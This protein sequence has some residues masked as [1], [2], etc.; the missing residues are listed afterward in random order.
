MALMGMYHVLGVTVLRSILL[1]LAAV[2]AWWAQGPLLSML[3]VV[4]IGL[5]VLMAIIEIPHP[6]VVG[7]RLVGLLS[8]GVCVRVLGMS[9]SCH[10]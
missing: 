7:F 3:G 5:T 4:A 6:G 10:R 1:Y 2:G 8:V 9:G